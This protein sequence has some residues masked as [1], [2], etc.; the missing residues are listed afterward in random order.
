MLEI[1]IKH[2]VI[3]YIQRIKSL[4]ERKIAARGGRKGRK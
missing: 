1:V 3:Y 2:P 4:Q